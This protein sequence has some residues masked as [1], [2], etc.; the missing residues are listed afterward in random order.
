MMS[1]ASGMGSVVTFYSWKGGVGR[2][3]ALANTAV[4]LARAGRKVLMID[5]DLEA[6][7]L[8]HYFLTSGKP[9]SSHLHVTPAQSSGGLWS[10]LHSASIRANGDLDPEE[11]KSA[12]TRITVPPAEP[13]VRSPYVPTPAPLDLLPTGHDRENYSE[14]LGD[15][16]WSAFF[17]DSRGGE[18][19]EAARRQWTRSYDFVLID[20]RTGLTDSGGV[21]TIQLPDTL[22]LVFA[23]NDQSFSGGM[24][25]AAAAQKA[26]RDY[27][28]DR[29]QLTIIPLLSRWSGGEEIEIA[30]E[31][32]RRFDQ[33]LRPV[34]GP[35]LPK[36]F[37]PRLF[38][39]RV[40]VPHVARFS[41]GEPLPVLTHSLTD[42]A[43]PGFAF[44]SLARLI[45]SDMADVAKIIDPAYDPPKFSTDRNISNENRWSMLAGDL[46]ALHR[47][48]GEITRINGSDSGE[49]S[50]A[51]SAAGQALFRMARFEEAE[52]L[53]RRAL[54]IDEKR[55][56]S[57]HSNVAIRLNNLAQLLKATNRLAEAEPLMRRAL[58]IS[59]ASL[60]PDHPNVATGLNNLARLL[61]DTNRLAEAEPLMRRMSVIL[62]AFQRTTGH[63]HP[64]AEAGVHNYRVLLSEMGW[65]EPAIHKAIESARREAGLISESG[66]NV[67]QIS[68][69]TAL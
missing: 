42:P 50:F 35:W 8:H 28:Y 63:K 11:W 37:T 54:A 16:S 10:L 43:L 38:V 39:E 31:W 58:A 69:H 41:F 64:H 13:G 67:P 6:P 46:V 61:Q 29:G 68:D 1:L 33:E 27:G 22:V 60:G 4:Q 19:L 15:F 25:I 7:G 56:A 9:E 40:R 55:L 18:W 59:E 32:M 66:S 65:N 48:L 52:P 23:A 57:D 49:L 26:R 34:T 14:E 3:L 2:T 45:A 17:R 20:S 36:S 62:L 24:K 47:E 53:M 5:W 12:I 51:L 44:D 21:C 30:E